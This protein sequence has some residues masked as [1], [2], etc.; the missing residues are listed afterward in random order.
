[1]NQISKDDQRLYKIALDQAQKSLSEHGIPIGAVLA[2]DGKIISKGHNQRIQ[3]N[4]PIAHGEIDCIQK[5]GRQT[6]YK[7][8]TLYTTLSPCMMCTGA[9]IQFKIPR[10]V[11]GENKNFEGNIEFLKA[12]DVEILLLNDSE[13]IGMMHDFIDLH[14]NLWNE[15]IQIYG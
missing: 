9:I 15:D 1:M 2:K 6:N 5:A 11:I 8:M 4:N 12:H 13:S 14:P 3:T 7:G 10:V